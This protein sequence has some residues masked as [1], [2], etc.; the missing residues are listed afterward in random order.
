VTMTDDPTRRHL[1]PVEPPYDPEYDRTRPAQAPE[2]E[3]ALLGAL[4]L[5]PTL[6]P[7]IALEI[8]PSDFYRPTHET[9]FDAAQAIHADPDRTLDPVTIVSELTRRGEINKIG[10]APYLHDLMAACPLP[11]SYAEYAKDV[12][13]AARIRD[14]ANLGTKLTQLGTTTD[15]TRI[16][17][18]L[19]NA[20]QAL[21][22]TV[23]RFGPR[24]GAKNPTGLHDLAWILTGTPPEVP[25]PTIC[26][27]TDGHALFYPGKVNG[28]FGDP[29]GGKTWLA[30]CAIVE[31]LNAGGNAA[32]IDVDHNGPDHT[33]ARLLLLGA[34]LNV[35]ADPNRFRYYEPEDADQL[36]AAV[37]DIT[38]RRPAVTLIDSL[39]EIFPM[40]GV[41]TNDG[42][43]ITT[44]MRQVCT[45]PAVAGS[46]VIT[47]DHLPK[48]TE[49]RTTGY[50]IGSIAKKRM[51]RG[52]YLRADVRVQPAPG[53][54]GLVTL[55]IE[56]DTAGELRKSS[57][58][59][60]AGTL[61]LDSTQ[62]HI[63][64]WSIGRDEMPK[65][66]DGT[67]RPTSLMEK[68]SR[69]IEQNDQC[70]FTDIKDAISGK[71][72]WLR[73]AIGLLVH[74]GFVARLDGARR[75]KL[76]HSIAPYRETEDDHVS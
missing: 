45:R 58:G 37:T 30:Q 7:A 35:I 72:K 69:Y 54:R 62:P 67:L 12:R 19:D 1:H 17:S 27:R 64:T 74:E 71:D 52:A 31:E 5:D 34:R 28:I 25:P 16:H 43:E 39:G 57:G 33:A 10:G 48:S 9:I 20:V 11:A 2:A 53:A 29:E 26:H 24:T 68:I 18:V 60:Y 15:L 70:T 6:A 22:D 73:D 63:T 55:R 13:D 56:K 14:V 61:I 65:N 3:R 47:I 4:L 49:A 75:A 36:L 8:D 41:N 59:G 50:A 32:M 51:I 76:H 46:C 40:L 38:N 21:D 44:A 23:A 42:D 66:D